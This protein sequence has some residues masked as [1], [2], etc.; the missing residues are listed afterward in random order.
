MSRS[1][2]LFLKKKDRV[3]EDVRRG[4]SV[5]GEERRR[6]RGP[7]GGEDIKVFTYRG[8]F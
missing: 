7:G 6:G 1:S 8:T 2:D 4:G 3:L 5:F